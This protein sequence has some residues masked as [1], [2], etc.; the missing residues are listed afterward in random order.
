[1]ASLPP[2]EVER[3]LRSLGSLLPS[4]AVKELITEVRRQKMD[5]AHFGALVASRTTP[6]L[7]DNVKPSHMATLR[8]CWNSEHGAVTVP[9][10]SRHHGTA[11]PPPKP[12]ASSPLPASQ[13]QQRPP[14][15]QIGGGRAGGTGAGGAGAGDAGRR[16]PQEASP[17]PPPLPQPPPPTPPPGPDDDDEGE[18]HP[19]GHAKAQ[20]RRP[21]PSSPPL[22]RLDLYEDDDDSPLPRNAPCFVPPPRVAPADNDAGGAALNGGGS[23]ASHPLNSLTGWQKSRRPPQVPRLDLAFIHGDA[24]TNGKPEKLGSHQWAKPGK[25]PAGVGDDSHA[26]HHGAR[27]PHGGH[28][29]SSN[30][31]KQPKGFA[32]ASCEDQQRIAEFY[33]Y[34]DEGFVATMHGLKTD[35]IRPRLY[36]GTM[37]D[38]AYWP[39]LQSLS[40]THILNCAIEAQWAQP[41]YES[42]GISYLLLPLQD[43]VEQAQSLQRQRFRILREATRF[44]HQSL[45]TSFVIGGVERRGSVLVH[46]VQGLSRSAVI[47]CAYLMEYEGVSMDRALGEVRHKHRGCLASQHWQEFIYKFNAELL[48]G[49]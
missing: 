41:P 30:E 45:K 1:M 40:I 5:G 7:G 10:R 28:G 8:R 9:L 24:G 49:L 31:E 35:C 42:Q 29:R 17:S 19:R 32:C 3:W 47:V 46:C 33:G 38:A 22:G 43:S 15:E 37:A 25:P 11:V 21:P 44:V 48:R 6:S 26:P 18:H 12:T 39:L 36:L 16:R 13:Q 14:L 2:L 34:R 23:Q 4:E 27:A 20:Q